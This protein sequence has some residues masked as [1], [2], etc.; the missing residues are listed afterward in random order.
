MNL[1]YSFFTL[2]ILPLVLV[3]LWRIVQ[4][5]GFNGAWSLLIF[6][7]GVNVIGLWLLALLE[8]PRDRGSR[9]S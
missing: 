8:W 5:A 6:I 7:P 4:R 1:Q 3:P 9:V 2:I